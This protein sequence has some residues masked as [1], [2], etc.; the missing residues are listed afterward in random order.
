MGRRLACAYRAETVSRDEPKDKATT[1]LHHIRKNKKDIRKK[2]NETRYDTIR[3]FSNAVIFKCLGS[4]SF[5][6]FSPFSDTLSHACFQILDHLRVAS[7]DM[8]LSNARFRPRPQDPSASQAFFN[9]AAPCPRPAPVTMS[10]DASHVQRFQCQVPPAVLVLVV[11]RSC[12]VR[13]P[14]HQKK[15]L[16]SVLEI[17]ISLSAAYATKLPTPKFVHRS[18]PLQE[19]RKLSESLFVHQLFPRFACAFQLFRE[20]CHRLMLFHVRSKSVRRFRRRRRCQRCFVL[21]RQAIYMFCELCHLSLRVAAPLP[22]ESSVTHQPR[23][24][25]GMFRLSRPRARRPPF[26]DSVT[27]NVAV[28]QPKPPRLATMQSILGLI[29]ACSCG[30]L[31]CRKVQRTRGRDGVLGN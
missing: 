16:R 25:A 7:E 27:A 12:S 28:R 10:F 8:V 18:T 14:C 1:H 24:F 3:L 29:T 17:R 19:L 26:H 5:H 22:R 11:T 6:P 15:P 2:K 9:V 23:L 21:P 30:P 13:L 31:D 20:R 4:L